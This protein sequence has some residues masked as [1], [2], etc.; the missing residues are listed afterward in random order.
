MINFD[1]PGREQDPCPWLWPCTQ[2]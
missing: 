2:F 1:F